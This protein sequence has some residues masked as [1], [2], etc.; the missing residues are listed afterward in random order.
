[1]DW[2]RMKRSGI[3]AAAVATWLVSAGVAMAIPPTAPRTLSTEQVIRIGTSYITGIHTAP[4]DS[5]RLYVMTRGGELW[6]VKGTVRN[7]LPMLTIPSVAGPENGLLG[8]AFAP[9]FQTSRKFYVFVTSAI[10]GNTR[11]RVLSYRMMPGDPETAD[12]SSQQIV[13]EMTLSGIHVGGWIG[14]GPDGYL[15]IARGDN[16]SGGAD[17]QNINSLNG[18]ILRIDPSGDDFPA[19]AAKN[20]AI[21]ASNPFAGTV[22]GGDEIFHLG[23]RN[24]FRCSF[25]RATGDFYIADVGQSTREEVNRVAAG[26]PGGRNFGWPCMEGFTVRSTTPAGCSGAG[27]N[28]TPPIVDLDRNTSACL[29]GGLVYRGCAI[30][31][32]QGRYIL[33]ECGGSRYLSFDPANAIA[34]LVMEPGLANGVI[35]WGEDHNGEILY[36]TSTGYVYRVVRWSELPA[37]A[38]CNANGRVDP[39]DIAR[40]FSQDSNIDGVPDECQTPPCPADINEDQTVS[41]DDIFAFLDLWFVQAGQIGDGLTADFNTDETVGA[42]DIFAFLDSWFAHL[43]PC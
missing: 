25:D 23:L 29:I 30:P 38:D 18:K 5:E 37:L 14:F 27:A 41:A 19:D 6:I 9:D 1:M 31:E 40:G 16:G 8:L 7:A 10:G 43:G 36:G 15:Y 24:P 17:S 33:G 32:L 28:N 20:Y 22:P 35:S 11:P 13:I 3:G 12:P 26:D 34:S 21:P 2:L 42:D 4:G 39:C